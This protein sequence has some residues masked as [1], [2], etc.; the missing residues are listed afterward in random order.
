MHCAPSDTVVMLL[1]ATTRGAESTRGIRR[2]R[3]TAAP[4][5]DKRVGAGYPHVTIPA[6]SPEAEPTRSRVPETPNE[7]RRSAGAARRQDMA[8]IARPDDTS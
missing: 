8:M 6:S 3:E 2:L 1:G 5:V 4:D 7:L